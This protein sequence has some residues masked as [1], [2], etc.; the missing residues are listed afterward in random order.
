MDNLVPISG[1]CKLN[2]CNLPSV[3]SNAQSWYECVTYLAYKI[4]ECINTINEWNDNYKK[5]TDNAIAELRNE[6][7]PHFRDLHSYI[8]SEILKQKQY[9]D[10]SSKEV[11]KKLTDVYVNLTKRIEECYT[12][13]D[14][15]DKQLRHQFQKEIEQVYFKISHLCS[16]DFY[17]YNPVKGYETTIARAIQ[18]LYNAVRY[19]A[20]TCQAFDDKQDTCTYYDNFAYTCSEF[21]LNSDDVFG[22][23]T[24]YY[25]F[26]PFTGEI[27]FYQDVIQKLASLHFETPI[28]ATQ[29]DALSKLTTQKFDDELIQAFAFDNKA[30]ALLSKFN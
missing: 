6:L 3:Y 25:M 20:I 12:L 11:I 29:F 17:M 8:D 15:I 5:Y 27:V 30:S 1:S 13:I 22:R 2:T 9:T 7:L 21:D 14:V 4:D 28:N 19:H 26:S 18:D 16:D 24:K 10:E 23:N